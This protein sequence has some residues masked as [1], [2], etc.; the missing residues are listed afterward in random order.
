MQV[1][2]GFCFINVLD[3]LK[4]SRPP[5]GHFDRNR[6]NTRTDNNKSGVRIN[7]EIKAPTIRVVDSEGNMLGIMPVREARDIAYQQEKDLVEIAPQANPPV[8]KIIDFGKYQYE[9]H[10]REKMQKKQQHQS[11][12]K[13]VRFKAGTDTHDFDFKTRHARE[14]LLEGDKVKATVFFRGREIQ[15]T[16][17]GEQL[18]LRFIEKLEDVSKVDQPLK[19]EGKTLSVTLAPDKEKQKKNQKAKTE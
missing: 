3:N 10:K 19:A 11:Q 4:S 16:E 12:L 14:F 17:F 1:V 5:Q 8:C 6:P 13:E 2:Y 15:H 18:L 7:E 9:L